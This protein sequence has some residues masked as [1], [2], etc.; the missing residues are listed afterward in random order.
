MQMTIKKH[1][2][3]LLERLMLSRVKFSDNEHDDTINAMEDP[4]CQYYEIDETGKKETFSTQSTKTIE[5]LWQKYHTNLDDF[6]DEVQAITPAEFTKAL[7]DDFIAK[8]FAKWKWLSDKDHK[9][10]KKTV[11][12]KKE[13]TSSV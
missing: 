1:Q 10:D 6:D 5:A 13:I 2:G 9:A 3:D 4:K 12:R 11:P 7:L 8:S